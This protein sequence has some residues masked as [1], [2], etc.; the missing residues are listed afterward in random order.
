MKLTKFT[1]LAAGIAL[2]LSAA[3]LAGC[4]SDDDDDDRSTPT[5]GNTPASTRTAASGGGDDTPEAE[6]TDDAPSGSPGGSGDVAEIKALARKFV[7]A[8]FSADYTV[9]GAPGESLSDGTVKLIKDGADKFRFDLTSSEGQIIFIQAGDVAAS[10]L[11]DAG[12]LGALLGVEAGEGV[13]FS[14]DVSG[15]GNLAEDLEEFV[16]GNVTVLETSEREIVGET[17]KCYLT[18]E[19]SQ[20]ITN[21]CINSDGILLAVESPDGSTL[22]ATGYSD[23]VNDSD[24]ELPYELRELPAAE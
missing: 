13:C 3:A 4:G 22:E 20:E 12:E 15:L 24:F 1:M 8:T 17:V 18:Q 10:C 16:S 14:Q 5:S 6:P 7:D 2:A 11:S 9:S 23:D 21:V 19:E